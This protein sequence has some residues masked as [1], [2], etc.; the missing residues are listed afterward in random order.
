MSG[1]GPLNPNLSGLPEIKTEP[2]QSPRTIAPTSVS[3]PTQ[4]P[5]TM[6]PEDLIQKGAQVV[7]GAASK[8]HSFLHALR[9]K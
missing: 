7:E 2:T 8:V 9:V 4:T 5:P 6:A 3:F 1:T